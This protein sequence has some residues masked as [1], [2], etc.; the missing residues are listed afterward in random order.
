MTTTRQDVRYLVIVSRERPELYDELTRRFSDDPTVE[1][2]VDRRVAERRQRDVERGNDR[3][4]S[5]R[6]QATMQ[7]TASLWLAG[8]VIVRVN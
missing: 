6:R 2:I 8:Y 7:V 5:D 3:R 1:V 4:T